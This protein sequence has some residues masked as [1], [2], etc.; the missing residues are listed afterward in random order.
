MT[1]EGNL[2]IN[3]LDYAVECREFQPE[4]VKRLNYGP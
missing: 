1:T 3:I 2:N 4:V